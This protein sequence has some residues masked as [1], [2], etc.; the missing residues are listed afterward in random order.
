MPGIDIETYCECA[1]PLS[2]HVDIERDL[3][4]ISVEACPSCTAD[5]YDEGYD[6]GFDEGYNDGY[7]KGHKDGYKEG[8]ADR[9]M[10][11]QES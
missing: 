2:S 1:K 4:M 6:K 5:K 7:D 8:Y 3:V 10:E 11:E 9:E